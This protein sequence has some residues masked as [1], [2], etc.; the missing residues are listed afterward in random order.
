VIRA[1]PDSGYTEQA[2]DACYNGLAKEAQARPAFMVMTMAARAIDDP[3]TPPPPPG[4]GA[5]VVCMLI[6]KYVPLA[7]DGFRRVGRLEGRPNEQAQSA[8]AVPA[9]LFGLLLGPD[10]DLVL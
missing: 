6:R 7:P 5:A 1:R 4:G 9:K 8:H 2:Y 10:K 3:G